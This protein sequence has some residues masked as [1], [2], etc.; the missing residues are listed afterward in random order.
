VIQCDFWSLRLKKWITIDTLIDT[1]A[2]YSL[3]PRFLAYNLGIDL[4]KD[5]E[6]I[7][8]VGVGGSETVCF[9]PRCRI[10]LGRRSLSIP[11]GFLSH[12]DIP[13]L[14][15]RQKCLDRLKILLHKHVTTLWV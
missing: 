14:L 5:C 10:R 4:K 8:T 13:V 2:D 3:L 15:G 1:G 12:N 9:Y 11:V 7:H 6:R